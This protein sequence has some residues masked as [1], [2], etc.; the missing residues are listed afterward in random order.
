MGD[1]VLDQR[2]L[3]QRR[4]AGN[5]LAPLKTLAGRLDD[6]FRDAA[7]CGDYRKPALFAVISEYVRAATRIAN[8]VP[9]NM[10]VRLGAYA[11][12]SAAIEGTSAVR[13]ETETQA[14]LE[15]C[16]ESTGMD[17]ERLTRD[18]AAWRRSA[19]VPDPDMR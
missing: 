12:L 10:A 6:A 18:P 14:L 2:L 8:N 4:L 9:S 16:P 11:R 1:Y 3:R 17:S 5:P 7:R 13:A 15:C 19:D